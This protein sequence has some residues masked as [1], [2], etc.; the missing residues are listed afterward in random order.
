[1]AERED[2]RKSLSQQYR[3]VMVDEYQDTNSIQ[4]DI[5]KWLAHEH[6]NIMVV[7]DDSQAIYS[8]R[9]ASY[10]N[11]FDFPVQFPKAK[12]IKL[13]ENYRS[14]QPILTLTNA[15][16]DQAGEKYTKC[17]FTERKG[18]EKPRIVDAKSEPEQA[19]FVC[20]YIK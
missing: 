5:V 11:M 9:G 4:A 2:V 19:L 12:L 16:M 3:Y 6:R 15:L 17:L 7:G 10:R 18:G 1:L 20:R 8:F 13:E 14:V